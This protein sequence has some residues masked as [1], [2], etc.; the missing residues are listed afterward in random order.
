[1][2]KKLSKYVSDALNIEF[3]TNTTYPLDLQDLVGLAVRRNPKRAHLLVS[4]VLGKHIPQNPQIIEFSGKLLGAMV[5]NVLNGR[6]ATAG[7]TPAFQALRH[8]VR[9]GS[10][11][12]TSGD[13]NDG[14]HW[15]TWNS[16][17]LLRSIPQNERV[18]ATI[19]YAETATALGHLVAEVL[20]SWYIHSTRTFDKDTVSYGKFEESHSHATSHK[21]IP[22]DDS[23]LNSDVP[24]VLI[25]DEFSTGKTIINTITELHSI[26]PHS[27]Y[28]VGALID[29]RNDNDRVVM[30]EFAESLGVKITVVALASGTVHV[31]YDA[32]EKASDIIEASTANAKLV[33]S[34]EENQKVAL[35]KVICPAKSRVE[36]RFGVIPKEYLPNDALV[37]AY[38]VGELP[39]KTLVLGTEEFLYFP[40][41]VACEL[42]KM[43]EN[44]NNVF[45]SST[46]QSPVVA[47]DDTS[48]AIKTATTFQVKTKYG[49]EKRYAYNIEQDFDNIVVLLEPDCDIKSFSYP[50]GLAATL[51]QLVKTNL[52]IVQL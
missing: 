23:L 52:V 15:R 31:P 32:I 42:N 5:S 36:T 28:I 1:M 48:Y 4:E 18:V 6:E 13:V 44:G 50:N 25:D 47:I 3:E 49:V 8:Y 17:L 24:I 9:G 51:S 39:G 11:F 14:S 45:S 46:T 12:H 7:L 35:R 26:H 40:L 2:S 21:L 10:S 20:D 30:S 33:S 34:N 16:R 41:M 38:S 19:G 29:C 22:H 43:A 27:E 37:V